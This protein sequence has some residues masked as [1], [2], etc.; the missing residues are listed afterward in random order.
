MTRDLRFVFRQLLKSP[1]F[2]LLALLT[3]A[4]GIGLNSAIF[5]LIDDL[6]LRGLPYTEPDRVVHMYAN[7]KAIARP[8]RLKLSG[9]IEGPPLAEISPTGDWSF[10]FSHA[11]GAATDV[12]Q[13]PSCIDRL[14]AIG[15]SDENC[16][17]AK[18]GELAHALTLGAHRGSSGPGASRRSPAD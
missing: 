13:L 6:F 12:A 7:A 15:P 17:L 9:N 18:P 11:I 1:G 5:S 16:L 2:T 4:I 10:R 14:V 3:L 8:I